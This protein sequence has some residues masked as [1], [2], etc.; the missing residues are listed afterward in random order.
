MPGRRPPADGRRR[1]DGDGRTEPEGDHAE[2]VT[3]GR[4]RD[5]AG[6]CAHRSEALREVAAHGTPNADLHPGGSA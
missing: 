5:R 2:E 6:Q 3:A 4:G 1:R